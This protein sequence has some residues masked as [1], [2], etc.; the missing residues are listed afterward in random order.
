MGTE[1]PKH[2]SWAPHPKHTFA[3]GTEE[4]NKIKAL[5]L[6]WPLLET[7]SIIRTLPKL[8]TSS[9]LIEDLF[10]LGFFPED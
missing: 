4:L 6:L 3:V 8:L 7:K 10:P 9:E 5:Q 1:A 2:T